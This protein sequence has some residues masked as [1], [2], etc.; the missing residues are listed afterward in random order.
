MSYLEGE[1][2]I[3]FLYVLGPWTY[4]GSLSVPRSGSLSLSVLDGLWAD[5]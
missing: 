3:L 4:D 1:S 5:P 2:W